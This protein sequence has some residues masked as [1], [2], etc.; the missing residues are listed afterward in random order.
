MTMNAEASQIK[1]LFIAVSAFGV[2]III[3]VFYGIMRVFSKRNKVT[4]KLHY[5]YKCM[6]SVAEHEIIELDGEAICVSCFSGKEKDT[7]SEE[8]SSPAKIAYCPKCNA[9]MPLM[10]IKCDECDYNFDDETC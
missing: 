5:C 8:D 1:F 4:E 10:A 9:E 6:D 2:F 3:L 7:Q